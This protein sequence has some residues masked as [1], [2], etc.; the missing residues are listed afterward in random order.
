MEKLGRVS[1]RLYLRKQFRVV[2]FIERTRRDLFVRA[3]QTLEFSRQKSRE[4]RFRTSAW[5]DARYR[6]SRTFNHLLRKD[7]PE[8]PVIHSKVRAAL[9][10]ML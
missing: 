6:S 4:S 8:G 3:F 9:A 10:D 2:Q 1:S 5:G 7:T